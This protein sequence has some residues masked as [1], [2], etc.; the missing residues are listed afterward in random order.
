MSKIKIE[1]DAHKKLKEALKKRKPL[2]KTKKL[3]SGLLSFNIL[4]FYILINGLII[5]KK[6]KIASFLVHYCF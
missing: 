4:N 3:Y 1:T 2:K 6:R 5:L